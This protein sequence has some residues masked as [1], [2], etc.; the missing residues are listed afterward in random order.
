MVAVV[1]FGSC[2]VDVAT[3]T[4][5]RD[6]VEQ[7]LEPQAFDLLVYLLSNRD[8]VVPKSQLLDEVWGDQFVSE[9]AL[10]TRIK[11]IRHALGDDGVRQAIVKNFRGRGYRFVA[12][13]DDVELQPSPGAGRSTPVVTALVGRD[14]DVAD[15]AELLG[16]AG[17]V[18]LVGPG[19]VGKT[20]LAYEAARVCGE[21]HS[22]GVRVVQLAPL[23][24]ERGVV[25]AFRRDT[26]LIDVGDDEHDLIGS[27]ADLDAVVVIDNCEHL[28]DEASRVADAILRAD[29]N[30]RL[31]A[32]SRERLGIAN[33]QVWPVAPLADEPARRL[34]LDRSRSVQPDYRWSP[35]EEASIEQL[36]TTLDRLPLAIEMAAARLPSIGAA[37]LA[38]L[39]RERLDL[40]RSADRTADDRHRT[41]RAL[42]SWSED[43]LDPTERDLLTALT[44][45]AGPVPVADIASVVGADAAE[46]AVGPLAG[47]VD[48]SLVATDTDQQPT[49]YRLLE[50]VRASAA[51]RRAPSI[52]ARHT[53]HIVHVVTE[54]D[55]MLRTSAERQA[56]S[57]IDGLNAEIR[58]AHRWARA[59]APHLAAEL[60][61]SL[62]LYSQDRQWT[63]PAIWARELLEQHDPTDPVSVGSSAA[64]AADAANRGDYELAARHATRAVEADDHRILSSAHDTLANIGLYTGDLGAAHHHGT[65][66]LD[67]GTRT[68]DDSIRIAGALSLVLGQVYAGRTDDAADILE[69]LDTD[70]QVAPTSR[71][72]GAYGQGEFFAASGRDAE[73]IERF[74]RVVEL[75]TSVGSHMTVGIAR[76]SSLAVK[77][78]SGDVDD[79]MA[80]FV[81]V[82]ADYRRAR[83]LTHAITALRNL[84]ELLVR[85]GHDE[86]AMVLLGALSNPNIKSTYGVES[87]N[88]EVARATV[89][90]R[91]G[92][93]AVTSWMAKGSAR[94]ATWAL[95]H[96]I[97]VLDGIGSAGVADV[98]PPSPG[99]ADRPTTGP[100]VG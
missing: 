5:V 13:P 95:D 88:L 17:L 11:E 27:I 60:T 79:A 61:A 42:V 52:D 74:E 65:I 78:R 33:E 49:R 15:V 39:L 64:L 23:R 16:G 50:T 31:L 30:V 92:S 91:R 45:F 83:S 72:Y 93:A 35:D 53:D 9:S 97:D 58:I 89:I 34:L 25:H 6:D 54:A 56:A 19:G 20:S 10:T 94:T 96:A 36:L 1:R 32:T 29:G 57:R 77:A 84:I 26:G 80:A 70:S 82:L 8:R 99:R 63:E 41:V 73:A 62:L 46:L 75:G 66:L 37:D 48:K 86:S 67:L 4:V 68:G 3:R 7:H 87:E 76:I 14:D 43:L 81:P 2:A 44:A 22:D 69:L 38:G 40:L 98:S 59:N 24:D 12:E 71:A 55:R 47:L 28:L 21:D 51:P 100:G 85:A 90:E 18:T